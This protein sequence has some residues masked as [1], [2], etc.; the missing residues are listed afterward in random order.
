MIIVG[1]SLAAFGTVGFDFA[2]TWRGDVMFIIS[3]I[4]FA[5]YMMLNRVW[6][7]STTQIWLCGS[8]ING[9]IFMPAWFW[10]LPSGIEQTSTNQLILQMSYQGIIPNIIGLVLVAVTVRNVGP[11]ISAA[12]MSGVPAL[13][14]FLG[15]VIL[16]EELSWIGIVSLCILT[17]G[18][19]IASLPARK[20]QTAD[21]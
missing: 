14:S 19:I 16:G 12:M 13:S 9:I 2:V 6:H 18:I 4:F 17:P 20:K 8:I 7:L 5:V 15:F 1:A 10:F 11:A 21:T 3:G